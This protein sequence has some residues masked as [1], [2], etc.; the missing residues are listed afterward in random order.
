MQLHVLD[1][2][3][4]LLTLVISLR[5]DLMQSEVFFRIVSNFIVSVLSMHFSDMVQSVLQ[6][7]E[8]FAAVIDVTAV[9]GALR[10]SALV[11]IPI[12]LG[13]KSRGTVR[14]LE[15]FLT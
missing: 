7:V 1:T 11:L 14:T 9:F 8:F 5:L 6:A 10:M 12:T 3:N 4:Y 2:S 15:W 13:C